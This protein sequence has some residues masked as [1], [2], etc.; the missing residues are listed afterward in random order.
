MWRTTL[1]GL[2]A[3]KLRFALTALSVVLGVAFMA[4]T[5]IITDTTRGALTALVSDDGAG[6]DVVVRPRPA[7]QGAAPEPLP[8]SVLD[9]VRGVDGVTAVEGSVSGVAQ[10]LDPAGDPIGSSQTPQMGADWP[11]VEALNPYDLTD[12]RAPAAADE[13]VM[14]RGTARDE[15]FAVGDA[16]AIVIAGTPET[17]RIVGIASFGEVDAPL[18]QSVALFEETRAQ[19]LFDAPGVYDDLTVTGDGVGAEALAVR[20]RAAVGDAEVLTGPAAIAEEQEEIDGALSAFTTFLLAFALISLFVGSFVISNTFSIVVAQRTR[21]MALLRALGAGRRAVLSAVLTEALVV[22]VLASAAG[23]VAGIGLSV[24]LRALLTTLGLELPDAD[25]VVA[26]RTIAVSLAVGVVVTL[27]AAF[28]PARKASRVPPIAALRDVAVE[29]TAGSRTRVTAGVLLAAVGA[30]LL[31]FGRAGDIDAP[32]PFL[33][34]GALAVFLGITVLGPALASP[35]SGFL[36]APLPWVKGVA[37]LLARENARRNPRRTAA[38][39]SAL[40]IGVALVAGITIL[41]SS[42]REAIYRDI[43]RTLVADLVLRDAAFNPLDAALAEELRALTEVGAVSGYLGDAALLD[44][45]PAELTAYDTGVVDELLDLGVVEGDL[46]ALSDGGL[47]IST[48]VAEER[49]WAVGQTVPV[50]FSGSGAAELTIEARYD[51]DSSAEGYIVDVATLAANAAEASTFQVF[52]AGRE[53]GDPAALRAQVEDLLVDRAPNVEVQ[54]PA[55][56]R[57]EVAGGVAQA[58]NFVYVLLGLAVVIAVIGIANTLALSVFERTRELGLLRAV[59]MTRSQLRS[60]VRW[61]SVLIAL[62]GTVLGLGVGTFFAWVFVRGLE[63]GRLFS[64]FVVPGVP[65]VGIVLAA[66][67]SGVLAAIGPARRAARLDVLRAI[68]SD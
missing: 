29:R 22:S 38:T 12:G 64:A 17:F 40:M 16:V 34:G 63:D 55:D 20:V 30:A 48:A 24:G 67:L 60:A 50:V 37:G 56:V 7:F 47:A 41:G 21:E 6:V 27:L 1:R 26:P 62:F 28:L 49:D 68:A 33:G 66:A 57:E 19:E 31:V 54:T 2:A 43:D 5:L 15:G 58:L 14:D 51:R 36:G 52:V 61:E 9:T 11:G 3:H 18:G 39:A 32:L 13:V 65:L 59:G 23:I 35:I 10:F 45:E 25:T 8:A 53:G 4:A 44:G 46:A 42:A